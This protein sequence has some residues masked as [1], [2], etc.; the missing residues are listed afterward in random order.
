MKKPQMVVQFAALEKA[1]QHINSGQ[2]VQAKQLLRE[3]LKKNPVN[4]DAMRLLG[5]A[6]SQGGELQQAYELY[7]RSLSLRMNQETLKSLAS[8]AEKLS[9]YDLAEKYYRSAIQLRPDDG[10]AYFYLAVLLGRKTERTADSIKCYEICIQLG[11]SPS[12]CYEN[13][14]M[15]AQYTYGNRDLARSCLLKA[16]EL[17]PKNVEAM[18][19]LAIIYWTYNHVDEVM[20][21]IQQIIATDPN[22]P[23]AYMLFSLYFMKLG[24]HEECCNFF[25]QA[26]DLDPN[27]P[28]L[29]SS[30]LGSTNYSEVLSKDEWFEAH[31]RY[32]DI[33][34]AIAPRFD[35][36]GNLAEPEKKLRV[37]YVS[38]DLHSHSVA[39]FFEPL[40]ENFDRDQFEFICY[41]NRRVTDDVTLRLKKLASEW[42]DISAL[43]DAELSALIRQDGVDLLVDLTG[44]T[45]ANRLSMF[46]MKP[47]P[48]Q[49][50]WLGYGPTTGMKAIDY[51][52]V[53]RYYVPDQLEERFFAEK[54]L[55]LNTYRVFRPPLD[56]PVSELPALSKGFV[57]FGSFNSF[58][59][60]SEELLLL[61]ADIVAA[62][63]NSR[64]AIIVNA[65][66][67]IDLV[68]K[69]FAS[70][71]VAEDRLLIFTKLKYDH[72]LQLHH[73]VDIA[74]DCYPHAG[75]TTSFNG[76]WMGVPMIS[77]IGPRMASRTGLGLLGPLGMEEFVADS[78]EQYLERAV[79]WA[80]NLPRL[81]EIRSGLRERLKASVLMDHVV[82]TRDFE[83]ALRRTWRTWC[84]QQ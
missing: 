65:R 3:F 57:T 78:Q 76:L 53:D 45:S 73:H 36:Y 4:A 63:P 48:V 60:I 26:V 32:G 39:T 61:W 8:T 41:Y 82:F 62:V 15:H 24:K 56:L 33:V 12:I 81:A 20:K 69:T 14:A 75:F 71:G 38:A 59:K 1:A 5:D 67:S 40:L 6:L 29:Y 30:Y 42:R 31:C 43:N 37:G 72:F 23:D 7:Q 11:Y 58:N 84:Q 66:E 64:F 27:N 50:T 70:R 2:L 47:A 51:I 46:A 34:S 17:D 68:K 18:Y 13:I 54:P 49:F 80:N 22:R 25:K 28:Q 83:A 52:F 9:Q 77:R 74:L 79:Y 55:Y 16:I 19:R 21:L 10:E 44:H 35:S